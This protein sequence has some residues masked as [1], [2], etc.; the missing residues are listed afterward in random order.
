MTDPEQLHRA[1]GA[2]ALTVGVGTTLAPGLFLRPFGI[3]AA[4]VTGAAQM[5]WRMFGIRTALIGAAAITGSTE[6]RAA[7]LPVQLAD[8]LVFAHAARSGAVPVRAA[9]LAQAVS[10]VLI[11]LELL[12][13][14]DA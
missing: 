1:A 10:G 14:R 12:A 13:A 8:Q 3:P 2:I 6:A 5:G 9:R 7:I 11:A 4:D